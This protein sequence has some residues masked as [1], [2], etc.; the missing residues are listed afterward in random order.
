MNTRNRACGA[1]LAFASMLLLTGVAT[2]ADRPY[3]E[4][5]VSVVNSIRT[6]PGMF[7]A[8]MKFLSTNWKTQMEEQK[9]AGIIVD[10]KVYTTTPRGPD[11]PN[12]YLVTTYKNMAAMD[13]MADK[14]EAMT[15]KMYGDVNQRSAAAIER[16]KMRKQMGSQMLR[17]QILK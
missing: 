8:Y 15:Q 5:P 16:E 12:I 11:D 3:T 4:G 6:E 10:Y 13:G 17:E 9:A 14:T 2:A 1:L 7:D